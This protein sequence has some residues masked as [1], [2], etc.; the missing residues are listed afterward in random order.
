M[1]DVKD[2]AMTFVNGPFVE[3]IGLDQSEHIVCA[4]AGVGELVDQIVTEG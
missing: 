4:L 1:S 3:R 2:D